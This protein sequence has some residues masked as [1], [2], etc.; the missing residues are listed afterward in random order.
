[1]SVAPT[2]SGTVSIP[3]YRREPRVGM[4]LAEATRAH[5]GDPPVLLS[6][7]EV[8]NLMTQKTVQEDHTVPLWPICFPRWPPSVPLTRGD[9]CFLIDQLRVGVLHS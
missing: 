4:Q 1:M 5:S 2:D 3:A 9:C 8:L 7:P 6:H